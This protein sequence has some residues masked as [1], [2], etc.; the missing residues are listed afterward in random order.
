[1]AT[2]STP[3]KQADGCPCQ[4][5]TVD[6]V[7]NKATGLTRQGTT[8]T[9]DLRYGVGAVHVVPAPNEQWYCKRL[10]QN[11]VLDRKLPQNTD[12]LANIVDNPAVGLTQIGSSG[13]T[14]GPLLLLGSQV[15]VSAPLGVMTVA[16][17]ARPDAATVGAGGHIFDTTLGKPIWSNGTAWVDSTGATA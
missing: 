8:I 2:Y 14:P 16:T 3:A 13:A 4:I 6:L 5:Q 10:N 9:I 11:W 12:V 15:N 1:M 17:T 7:T